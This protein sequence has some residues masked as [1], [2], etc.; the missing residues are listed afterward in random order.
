VAQV[1][2]YL[3]VLK[4]LASGASLF[5][6]QEWAHRGLGR[7][8]G[9]QVCRYGRSWPNLTACARAGGLRQIARETIVSQI[10]KEHSSLSTT[11]YVETYDV[12]E[13][14]SHDRALSHP[15]QINY[16]PLQHRKQEA[17]SYRL[18]G[19]LC[20]TT[21]LI[22]LP[23]VMFRPWRA[24]PST[25]PSSFLSS[26]WSSD[27]G[28]VLRPAGRFAGFVLTALVLLHWLTVGRHDPFRCDAL[29][30]DGTWPARDSVGRREF[31][32]WEPHGCRM[33]EYSREHFRDCLGRRRV[34]FAGDSTTRQLF[35]AAAKRLD[36][37]RADEK[38]LEVFVSEHLQHDILLDVEGV[39]L[40]FVWD[41]WLNSSRL[42]ADLDRFR[43][44]T[45]WTTVRGDNDD[46]AALLV[47]GAPGLWAA[48]NGGD[49]YLSLFRGGVDTAVP[50][51]HP[52][53]RPR[54][55]SPIS[56]DRLENQV[57][58]AAVQ[59]PWYPRLS[60]RRAQTLSEDRIR[61]MNGQL[62]NLPDDSRSRVITAFN[63]MS[64]GVES[65]VFVETGLH[66]VEAVAERWI[67]VVLNARC[68][69]ALVTHG[70]AYIRTCC[71]GYPT[72]LRGQ[73]VVMGFFAISALLL[74]ASVRKARHL[75][76]WLP[77]STTLKAVAVIGLALGY[78]Y[79]AD[80]TH[81]FSKGERHYEYKNLVYLCVGFAACCLCSVRRLALPRILPTG[82]SP[83]QES[84][85]ATVFLPRHVSDEWKGLM[86]G[87]LLLCVF[88]ETED[89]LGVHKL[90]RFFVSCYIFL[91][92]YG[93]TT[94]FLRSNEYSFCRV[95]VVCFRLNA[96]SCAAA[97][98]VRSDWPLYGFTRLL[99]F[100]F[101]VTYATLRLG[102]RLN[103]NPAYALA[104]I[105]GSA[106]IVTT[107]T[108]MPST[109]ELFGR[110]FSAAYTLNLTWPVAWPAARIRDQLAAHRFVPYLGMA[111]AV[112]AH[113]AALIKARA[114]SHAGKRPRFANKVDDMLSALLFPDE[115]TAPVY[116]ILVCF[117]L[118]FLVLFFSQAQSVRRFPSK[119][120]YDT[121]HPYMSA[122]A[123]LAYAQVRNCHESLRRTYL[124]LPAALS[125]TVL[126]VYVL[127][128]HI[129]LSGD[130]TGSLR[131]G[132]W[133]DG[134][135]MKAGMR[136]E[137]VILTVVLVW[138][139]W[140][141]GQAAQHLTY[142]LSGLEGAGRD[143]T[144]N[145]VGA[146][147]K[148]RDTG[149]PDALPMAASRQGTQ[150]DPA[151]W[152]AILLGARVRGAVL[153]LA[154]FGFWSV[155]LVY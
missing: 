82:S 93:H 7:Q 67:D 51:L 101:V 115:F 3:P 21:K 155:N 62:D 124:A 6:R 44:D 59:V 2:T 131:T 132:F 106:L 143:K 49:D 35:F 73:V 80:R 105:V 19:T 52:R 74:V 110:S 76:P 86:Q 102:R 55:D 139:S 24:S 99:T 126:E 40:E 15:R 37:A 100:W 65:R 33:H 16:S 78:C 130:G 116:P 53:L 150:A 103:S 151:G 75:N 22:Q 79:L 11:L 135:L 149:K 25:A 38:F 66:I 146:A 50:R 85:T 69:G 122:F 81:L 113:R 83:S 144:C 1:D 36:F 42:L 108:A 4:Y 109:I 48:R 39:R 70:M 118:A 27:L 26:P 96:V 8:V 18:T 23:R 127:H 111:A 112:L 117:S 133:G 54:L 104:K 60:S 14:H 94:Y 123:V 138:I 107:L 61:R 89:S 68:N 121:Y 125:A 45:D 97:L 120:T 88:H 145:K 141:V 64:R 153:C 84:T 58:L 137:A 30:K 47:L 10:Q 92:T 46:P 28:A 148:L 98:L 136:A 95:A 129:L 72:L 34:V 128:H 56:Y 152:Q 43:P 154:A 87:V 63:A 140:E 57:L 29:L 71:A 31:E 9:G 12:E 41:P 77:D 147:V 91:S 90:T 17:A 20:L 114:R 32:K 13:V 119:E 142:R 5:P 134:W